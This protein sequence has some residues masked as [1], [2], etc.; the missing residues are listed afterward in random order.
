MPR[1]LEEDPKL[2]DAWKSQ[3]GA[4]HD[5]RRYQCK[6]VTPLYGGGVVAGVVDQAMPV[7]PSGVRGQLRFW[8]RM[9]CAPLD[10]PQA[11]FAAE[12]A[13]WGGIGAKGPKASKVRVRVVARPI[14]DADLIPS[15][16]EADPAIRYAFGP[17]TINGAAQWLKPGYGFELLLD[18]P[19]DLATEVALA[20]GWWASFGGLGARTRRGFGAIQIAGLAPVTSEMV[21]ARG[22]LLAPGPRGVGDPQ[23]QW[24]RAVGKL[25]AFRQGPKL[26]R[27]AGH[28]R[29]SRSYWPEPD[30]IRRFFPGKDA[31]GRHPPAHPAGNVFPRAAFGL[32]I[33]FE[34]PGSPRNGEPE[35][36]ELLP[37]GDADR[38][39]S[40]LVVRPY[41][42]GRSWQPVALL[43]PRWKAALSMPLR[44]KEHHFAPAHWPDDAPTRAR[45]AAAIQPLNGRADDPLTAFL[46][47]FE[48]V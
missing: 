18:Y 19:D 7:R 21:E 4:G 30:Q 8:W 45:V 28:P 6:L 39:A 46:K 35:T 48:E 25:F 37:A 11:M 5:W 26:G 40:P 33:R 3:A 20:L 13:I 16:A 23:D 38:M 17:A 1:R 43:L 29:P 22:G 15:D 24:R 47:F 10:D 41:W 9:A 36:T 42:N 2:L 14:T 44:F 12:S 32:P 34:F 27:R 31:H